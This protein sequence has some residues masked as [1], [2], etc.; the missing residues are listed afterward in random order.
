MTDAVNPETNEPIFPMD[1]DGVSNALKS[2]EN[3]P[4]SHSRS[5][6]REF[7]S[8]TEIDPTNTPPNSRPST[9]IQSDSEYEISKVHKVCILKI[10]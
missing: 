9:P 8:D 1:E 2:L 6:H 7:F 4:I 5:F 3:G 10:Y